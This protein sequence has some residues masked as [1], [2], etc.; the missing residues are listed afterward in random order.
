MSLVSRLTQA[1][2]VETPAARMQT[3]VSPSTGPDLPFAAWWTE[4]PDGTAGPQHTL[5]GDQLVVVT[6]GSVEIRV[7]DESFILAAGDALKL[8]A[9]AVR[10]IRATAGSA[11]TLTIGHANARARVG[12]GEAV[13]VP[14]TA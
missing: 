10:V 1:K 7:G 5:D 11:R 8:P 12:D 3:L 14:W 4:L 9:G 2:T 6:N 13:A